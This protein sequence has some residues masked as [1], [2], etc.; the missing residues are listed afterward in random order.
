VEKEED[1]NEEEEAKE[2]EKNRI[3]KIRFDRDI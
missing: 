2:E 1:A 3:K